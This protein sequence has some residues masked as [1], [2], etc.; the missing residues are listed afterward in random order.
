MLVSI[1]YIY[2]YVYIAHFIK[3]TFIIRVLVNWALLRSKK[4]ASSCLTEFNIH[5]VKSLRF[6][7]SVRMRENTNQKTVNTD[8]FHAGR[9]D[10]HTLSSL[11]S[12]FG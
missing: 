4:F 6:P 8:T 5:C 1:K 3:K 9:S 11:S 12:K 7:S 2:K 10:S